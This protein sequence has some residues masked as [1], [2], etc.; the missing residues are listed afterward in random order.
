MEERTTHSFSPQPHRALSSY[1]DENIEPAKLCC[2]KIE[3]IFSGHSLCSL[4]LAPAQALAHILWIKV[5]TLDPTIQ[6]KDLDRA[7]SIKTFKSRLNF[8]AAAG[9]ALYFEG[10]M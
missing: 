8:A 6:V 10:L 9:L 4:K 2:V 5:M 1:A 3:K 7:L